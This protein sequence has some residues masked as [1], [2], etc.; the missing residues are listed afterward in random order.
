MIEEKK[1][2]EIIHAMHNNLSLWNHTV[3]HGVEVL[4]DNYQ[5]MLKLAEC[6]D[7]TYNQVQQKFIQEIFEKIKEIS[8]CIMMEKAE[9]LEQIKKTNHSN[10]IANEYVKGFSNPYFIDKDF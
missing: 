1:L 6:S 7:W 9:T 8:V 3:D 4:E 10:K 2:D 5:I